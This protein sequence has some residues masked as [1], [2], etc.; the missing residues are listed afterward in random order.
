MCSSD[1]GRPEPSFPLFFSTFREFVGAGAPESETLPNSAREKDMLASEPSAVVVCVDEG[2]WSPTSPGTA[3]AGPAGEDAPVCL[4]FGGEDF[5]ATLR[6]FPADPPEALVLLVGAPPCEDR[7]V[8]LKVTFR[9][10][11]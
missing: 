10:S 7:L 3:L 5:K 4:G 11:M 2:P 6:R 8:V 1:L 9:T